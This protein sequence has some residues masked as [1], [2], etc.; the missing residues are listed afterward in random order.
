[1]EHRLR[2]DASE[3]VDFLL[4]PACCDQAGETLVFLVGKEEACG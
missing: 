2:S 1:M 4:D 3:Y